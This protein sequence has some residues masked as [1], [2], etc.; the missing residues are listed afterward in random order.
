MGQAHHAE[1]ARPWVRHK[2]TGHEDM[3]QGLDGVIRHGLWTKSR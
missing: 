1:E 2:T 3:D